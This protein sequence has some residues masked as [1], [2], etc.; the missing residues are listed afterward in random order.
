[1]SPYQVPE[2]DAVSVA[3]AG[4]RQDHRGVAGVGDVDGKPGRDEQRLARRDGGRPVDA[5]AQIEPRRPARRVLGERDFPPEPGI[6][7][8]KLN[9][10]QGTAR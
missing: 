5:G 9:V 10:W 2:H 8:A 7:G 1:M 3:E 6:K 4:A